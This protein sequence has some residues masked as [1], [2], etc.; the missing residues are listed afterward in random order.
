VGIPVHGAAQERSSRGVWKSAGAALRPSAV[1]CPLHAALPTLIIA[2]A[3][4]KV[5]PNPSELDLNQLPL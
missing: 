1:I 3:N 5:E 4:A 2:V